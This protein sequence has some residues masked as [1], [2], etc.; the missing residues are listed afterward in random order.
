MQQAPNGK[1]QANI[2]KIKGQSDVPFLIKSKL[3]VLALL[4]RS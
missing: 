3:Y 4:G 1:E 2:D